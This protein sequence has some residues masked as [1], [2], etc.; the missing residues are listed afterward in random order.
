MKIKK[1]FSVV[2]F[3]FVVFVS[4]AQDVHFSQFTETPQLL[5]PGATGVYSGYM[6]GIINYKNNS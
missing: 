1:Q 2:I 3:C 5:N 6:R 4:A